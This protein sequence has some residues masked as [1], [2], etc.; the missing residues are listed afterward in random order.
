MQVGV[1]SP[2]GSR[3]CGRLGSAFKQWST[4]RAGARAWRLAG[5]LWQRLEKSLAVP[6]EEE[7]LL[8]CSGQKLGVLLCILECMGQPPTGSRPTGHAGQVQ[9]ILMHF[10]VAGPCLAGR[11]QLDRGPGGP[12]HAQTQTA[13]KG[14]HCGVSQGRRC[15]HE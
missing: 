14:T 15:R 9:R 10:E 11:P 2:G 1:G 4:P 6:A 12:S 13:E 3:T 5:D 8:A 7:E